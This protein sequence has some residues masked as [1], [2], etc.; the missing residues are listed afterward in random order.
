MNAISAGPLLVSGATVRE[1][2]FGSIHFVVRIASWFELS[3]HN[4]ENYGCIG[5][6]LSR[7]RCPP[8]FDLFVILGAKSRIIFISQKQLVNG[9]LWNIV[10]GA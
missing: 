9:G 2:C 3:R 1:N 7:P 4:K 6:R 8:A 5:Y 10:C